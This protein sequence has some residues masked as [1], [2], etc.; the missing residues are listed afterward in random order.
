MYLSIHGFLGFGFEL[1]QWI[2]ASSIRIL[3]FAA[4]SRSMVSSFVT[5]VTLACS[6]RFCKCDFSL[7]N[8]R[9]CWRSGA[10]SVDEDCE[11][12]DPERN[13]DDGAEDLRPLW[14]Y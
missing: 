13:D 2:I 9:L 12:G 1:G 14:L 10:P 6:S 3:L 8:K 5:R 7:V 11:D 4:F